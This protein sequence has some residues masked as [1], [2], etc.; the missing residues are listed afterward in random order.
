LTFTV[1]GQSFGVKNGFLPMFCAGL[2]GG[3]MTA[4]ILLGTG[5]AGTRTSTV[6]QA[7]P[8]EAA[9]SPTAGSRGLSAREIYRRGAP[10][11]VLVRARSLQAESS[12]LDASQRAANVA[13]G[14]A[15]V[16]DEEGHLLTNAHL[17]AGATDLRVA[18]DPATAVPAKVVGK[19]EGTDLAV[20]AVD[21]TKA[22]LHPLALGSSSTV[23]V[24]DPTVSIGNP[25]G[26][27]ATLTT[28]IIAAKEQR[29]TA[30][31][32][33]SISGVL[34][35]DTPP[36]PGAAGGPLFDSTGRVIGVNSQIAAGPDGA[37]GVGFA[38]PIDTAKAIIPRLEEHLVVSHAYLGV[39]A[40]DD[41][42]GL[43]AMASS[44]SKGVRVEEVDPGGPAGRAGIIGANAVD[45]GGGDVITAVDGREVHSMADV[46][47]VI[48]RHRPGD[49]VAVSLLRDG[50]PLTVQVQLTER[51]ASVPLG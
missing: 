9:A 39:R 2:L 7:P 11:V 33:F 24:G 26:R 5:A 31:S 43:V 13:T 1:I 49:G 51:P 17:V 34:Q 42:D 12:S 27:A 15:F 48:R 29:I 25:Y 37:A 21:P 44:D 35:T 10:G 30:P 19:D 4:A 22:A 18:F 20:L 6:V 38:I 14:S 46:E 40:G 47:N 36:S 23:E 3:G 45:A 41:A 32:G 28:G 16:L 8:L 50:R